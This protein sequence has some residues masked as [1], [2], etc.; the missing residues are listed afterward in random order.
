VYTTPLSILTQYP[1]F[2][3]APARARA[4]GLANKTAQEALIILAEWKALHAKGYKVL[5]GLAALKED[6]RKA[7]LWRN[8]RTSL[9][10]R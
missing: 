5:R 1:A 8:V 6:A 2:T 4:V 9:A 10:A 3:K 7:V